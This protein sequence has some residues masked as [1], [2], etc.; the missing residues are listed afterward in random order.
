E[1]AD[2]TDVPWRNS[3]FTHHELD[4][5][6]VARTDVPYATRILVRRPVDGARCNRVVY[7]EPLHVLRD[8]GVGWRT[9]RA[10]IMRTGAVWI[11]L[12]ASSGWYDKQ[13]GALGGVAYLRESDPERY[14]SLTL[15]DGE[16]SLW[17]LLRSSSD[18]SDLAGLMSDVDWKGETYNV[19]FARV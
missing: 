19:A 13:H 7:I 15:D 18:G 2:R 10:W 5:S 1:D 9:S 14:G 12:T 3:S 8:R 4:F 17:P 11:G 6:T 16:A